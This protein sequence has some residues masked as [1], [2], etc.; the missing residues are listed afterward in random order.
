MG[1]GDFFKKLGYR[2]QD[3]D[4]DVDW[5]D[6]D[7]Q[8]T[9]IEQIQRSGRRSSHKL[10][11]RHGDIDWVEFD[12]RME[13]EE[14]YGDYD[15]LDDLCG[16]YD[17]LEERKAELEAEEK[18]TFEEKEE[19]DARIERI[20]DEY[21]GYDKE[22]D[23]QGH[24]SDID[25]QIEEEKMQEDFD[26]VFGADDNEDDEDEEEA[27]ESEESE[28]TIATI[29]FSFAEPKVEPKKGLYIY[30]DYTWDF[31]KAIYDNFSELRNDYAGDEDLRIDEFLF[32]IAQINVSRAIGYWKWVMN[33]FPPE[34][35]KEKNKTDGSDFDDEP[36]GRVLYY[37]I[38][39]FA[40]KVVA[41][42]KEEYYFNYI[43]KD[44]SWEKH[45]VISI[46]EILESVYKAD[47]LE[48]FKKCYA[49]YL[50]YQKG[51]YTNRDLSKVWDRFLTCFEWKEDGQECLNYI[52]SEL[53]KI[54]DFGKPILK[55]IEKL[56]KERK[57]DLEYEE[58]ER[59]EEEEY[60]KAREAWEVE[61]AKRKRERE[62]RLGKIAK[63][64]AEVQP[65]LEEIDNGVIFSDKPTDARRFQFC[66]YPTRKTY[67]TVIKYILSENGGVNDFGEDMQI[68]EIGQEDLSTL[69]MMTSISLM[70][71]KVARKKYG[72]VVVKPFENQM[73]EINTPIVEF[74]FEHCYVAKL[75][76][77]LEYGV[78]IGVHYYES[79]MLKKAYNTYRDFEIELREKA[80]AIFADITQK[81]VAKVKK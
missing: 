17:D 3:F 37:L 61:E 36:A 39:D 21:G 77:I 10:R 4:G 30:Y 65:L 66:F 75:I 18:M 50:Q 31:F 29:S 11:N 5:I 7:I 54:G 68:G 32:E 80:K 26:I 19:R 47:G 46:S 70:L 28:E 74:I 2:D 52:K 60:R 8:N 64:E 63:L 56:E 16:E 58:N 71:H 25:E 44:F 67:D 72:N 13:I 53:E 42:L 73:I 59:R 78:S 24:Y 22:L 27:E 62:E 1:K 35:I 76:D 57:D 14:I 48:L 49:A 40:E 69:Y 9:E 79:V 81:G 34:L 12:R 43:F 15:E 51:Q 45:D 33:T 23:K 38:G 6:A 41:V 55:N 20:K